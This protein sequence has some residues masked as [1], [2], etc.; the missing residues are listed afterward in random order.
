LPPLL[1]QRIG[2]SVRIKRTAR[3]RRIWVPEDFARQFLK[4]LVAID[5]KFY[6]GRVCVPDIE[7]DL[8]PRFKADNGCLKLQLGTLLRGLR[9]VSAG[10]HENVPYLDP[11]GRRRTM[12][13]YEVRQKQDF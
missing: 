13:E 7:S 11:T 6:N 9:N 10:K 5:P 12:T 4:W 2:K 3:N 1:T 8:F